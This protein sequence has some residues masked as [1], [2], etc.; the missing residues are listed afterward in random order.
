[1]LVGAGNL[2]LVELLP[3][4]VTAGAKYEMV[5]KEYHPTFDESRQPR[6]NTDIFREYGIRCSHL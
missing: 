2:E 6:L 4:H 3:Y 1:M 5:Q